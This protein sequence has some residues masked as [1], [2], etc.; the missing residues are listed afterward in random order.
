MA[1]LSSL[2]DSCNEKYPLCYSGILAFVITVCLPLN[3]GISKLP[4]FGV[5]ALL[6]GGFVSLFMLGRNEQVG[7]SLLN[8][9]RIPDK[10]K[11]M[12]S[13]TKLVT[14]NTA[15]SNRSELI[16]LQNYK[17]NPFVMLQNVV[18]HIMIT[19]DEHIN[20]ATHEKLEN[21]RETLQK[22]KNEICEI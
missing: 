11:K 18:E 20:S 17:N 3:I 12:Q 4:T 22:I 16:R 15:R 6:I 5:F 7:T 14:I 19:H 9:L 13:D 1:S 21:V 8:H 10:K 2:Y